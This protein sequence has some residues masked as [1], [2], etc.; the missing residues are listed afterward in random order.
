MNCGGCSPREIGE[1]RCSLNAECKYL[2]A[3]D[4]L[5]LPIF[6][7]IHPECQWAVTAVPM[8]VPLV[9]KGTLYCL[10]HTKGKYY[11]E[12]QPKCVADTPTTFHCATT[13]EEIGEVTPK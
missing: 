3:A 12:F 9:C 10:A 11:E 7:P 4:P 2:D 13:C 8:W 5:N 1:Q 6:Q